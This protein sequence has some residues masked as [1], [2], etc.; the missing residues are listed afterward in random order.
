[1][2]VICCTPCLSSTK[3]LYSTT[4]ASMIYDPNLSFDDNSEASSFLVNYESPSDASSFF[5]ENL[6]HRIFTNM[7]YGISQFKKYYP[8]PPINHPKQ[9]YDNPPYF[10]AEKQ[11]GVQQITFM[12]I[13]WNR[14]LH[15]PA[16][17]TIYHPSVFHRW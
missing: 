5:L 2:K 15:Q 17:P 14:I 16:H 8:P 1:M 11:N 7:K 9:K 12:R 3:S 10:G 4:S 6:V 13:L